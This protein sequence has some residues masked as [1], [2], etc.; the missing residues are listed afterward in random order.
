MPVPPVR[1]GTSSWSS[2]DWRGVF[3][4][5]RT[6]PGDFL[7]HYAT[8]FDTVECDATFYGIPTADTVDG[9]RAGTP[10]GFV[11]SCKLPREITH[12]RGM[13]DCA[14]PLADFAAAL[15]RLGD[16][17]GPIVAQFAYVAKRRDAAE[18]ASG[19]DFRARLAGFLEQWPE[20]LELVVEVR[21]ARWIAPPLLD[22]LRE[23]GVGLVLPAYYTMPGPA[24]L[25]AGPEPVTSSTLYVRFLGDHREMDARVARLREAGR[26]SGEWSELALDRV[27]EMRDWVAPLRSRAEAGA[28]VLVYFNNHYAGYAPGSVDQFRRLWNE[29]GTA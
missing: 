3:Y 28:R 7:A 20:A 19:D 10:A 25:F 18:Y 8:R 26:R 27:D 16:R 1:I 23:R 22:L 2:P 12:D 14:R 24:R 17:L 11:F 13:V 4:P 29:T 9:W 15:G 5:P 21:N 6:R